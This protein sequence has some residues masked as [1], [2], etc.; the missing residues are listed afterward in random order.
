MLDL[1]REQEKTSFPSR[2]SSFSGWEQSAVSST[3]I[4]TIRVSD[5]FGN[6]TNVTSSCSIALQTNLRNGLFV[7]NKPINLV[8]PLGLYP[9]PA[10]PSRPDGVIPNFPPNPPAPDWHKNR[11]KNQKCP[12][13]KPD[14]EGPEGDACPDDRT[15]EKDYDWYGG[16]KGGSTYRGSD[17]SECVYDQ[18]GDLMPDKGTFNYG[19]DPKSF[20]HITKDV[21]PWLLWGN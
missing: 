15:W 21:I 14:S 9:Y 17:G 13:K 12:P 2:E 20:D 16:T 11:N 7:G 3:L 18:N 5:N 10:Y 19:P 8:D 4:A 6:Q 1:L